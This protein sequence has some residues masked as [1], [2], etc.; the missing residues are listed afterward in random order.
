MSQEGTESKSKST[1]AKS[2]F[3]NADFKLTLESCEFLQLYCSCSPQK[4]TMESTG[5]KQSHAQLSPQKNFKTAI[6]VWDR[7]LPYLKSSVR[8]GRVSLAVSGD[9]QPSDSPGKNS[10]L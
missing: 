10:S 3:L 7:V 5:N 8:A 2:T 1:E 9:S 4:L 6:G